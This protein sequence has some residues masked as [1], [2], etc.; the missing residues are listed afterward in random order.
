MNAGYPDAVT[1]DRKEK[2]RWLRSLAWW[3]WMGL[4]VCLALSPAQADSKRVKPYRQPA[5]IANAYFSDKMHQKGETMQPLSVVKA[6]RAGSEGVSGY[7]VLDLVLVVSGEHH[8]K[9]DIL[10]REGNLSTRLDYPPIQAAREEPLP[11]YAA[12]GT[13][14]GR[15]APGLWFFKVFDQLDRKGWKELG[16]MAILVVAPSG[17]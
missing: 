6:L 15:M 11:M 5:Y 14:S 4:I 13:I 1:V 12:V 8:F 16:T 9:V 2:R 10:D 3:G 17:E 7:F